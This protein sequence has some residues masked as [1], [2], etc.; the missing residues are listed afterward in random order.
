MDIPADPA[1]DN[2]IFWNP[3]TY[4][5]RDGSE[6]VTMSKYDPAAVFGGQ[7]APPARFLAK[8][9]FPIQ[10]PG[11]NGRAVTQLHQFLG[12]LEGVSTVEEAFAAIPAQVERMAQIEVER[13]Q[14]LQ[15][16]QSLRSTG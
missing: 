1:P 5:R 9:A 7:M 14:G 3:Q 10:V 12:E 15:R 13:I 4:T 6:V 8:V 2:D 16:Q 11:P